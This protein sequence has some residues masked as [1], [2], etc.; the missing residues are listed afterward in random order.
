LFTSGL[1]VGS[2]LELVEVLRESGQL[3]AQQVSEHG[4]VHW[5]EDMISKG[6]GVI[7]VHIFEIKY[8][9]C[10]FCPTKSQKIP[11]VFH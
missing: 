4:H 7:L 6:H 5:E 9:N 1:F 2:F 3:E 11:N 10:L 8:F